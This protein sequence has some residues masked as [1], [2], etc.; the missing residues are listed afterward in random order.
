M[1]TSPALILGSNGLPRQRTSSD[2]LLVTEADVATALSISTSQ[3]EMI[4]ALCPDFRATDTTGSN[5]VS[6]AGAYRTIV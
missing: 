2:T 3:L 4:V 6:D 5:R 1:S